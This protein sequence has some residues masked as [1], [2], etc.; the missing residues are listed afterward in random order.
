MRHAPP[1]E[2]CH[3]SLSTDVLLS[4][5]VVPGM[6]YVLVVVSF[7]GWLVPDMCPIE[8]YFPKEE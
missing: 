1:L 7:A 6:A 3:P 5:H 4:H 8:N 2:F